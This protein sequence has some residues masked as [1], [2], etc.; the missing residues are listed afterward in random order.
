MPT[1]EPVIIGF[2]NGRPVYR[3]TGGSVMSSDD[4]HTDRNDGGMDIDLEDDDD[5]DDKDD[6]RLRDNDDD[7]GDA[8]N[9]DDD[10]EPPDKV[11]WEKMRAAVKNQRREIKLLKREYEEKVKNLTSTASATNE[12]EVEKARI[13]AERERDAYWTEEIVHA[14]AAAEFTAQGATAE[15]AERL[16]LMVNMRKVEWDDKEREFDGLQDEIDDIVEANP[17][18]FKVRGSNDDEKPAKR[19]AGRPRVDGA[20]RGS[21]GGGGSGGAPRKKPRT[22]DIIANQAL[23]RGA[24]RRPSR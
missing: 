10:W 9:R 2:I 7:E 4:L 1:L 6:K 17:E 3:I 16:A 24:R 20:S 18:F 23:G 13:K 5:D 11:A 15:M 14:R 22:A 19:G 12:V 21:G 8:R